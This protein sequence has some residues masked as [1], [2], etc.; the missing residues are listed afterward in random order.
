MVTVSAKIDDDLKIKVE[1]YLHE[2]G[3][4][5]STAINLF[6]KEIYETKR[7]PYELK[8]RNRIKDIKENGA[9]IVIDGDVIHFTPDRIG[10]IHELADSPEDDI[11]D[12]MYGHLLEK[13]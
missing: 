3:L 2:M 5:I 4:N 13:K 6:F 7:I 12:E 10:D 8:V 11:Y 1:Y 9:D